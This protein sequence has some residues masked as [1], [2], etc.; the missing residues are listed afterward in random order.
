MGLGAYEPGVSGIEVGGS[1]WWGG[2]VPGCMGSLRGELELV[3]RAD[4][5]GSLDTWVLFKVSGG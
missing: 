5:V 4:G 3:V 1:G 2:R